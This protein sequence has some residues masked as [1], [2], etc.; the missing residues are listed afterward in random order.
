MVEKIEPYKCDRIAL[1]Y[2]SSYLI[3]NLSYSE[4]YLCTV[5]L[6]DPPKIMIIQLK[7]K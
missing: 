3:N 6:S 2:S 7:K 5:K 4:E 1:K